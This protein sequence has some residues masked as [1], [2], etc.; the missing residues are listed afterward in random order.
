MDST[1]S[2]RPHFRVWLE[3]E[4]YDLVLWVTNLTNEDAVEQLSTGSS[5]NF[6]SLSFRTSAINREQRRFGITARYRF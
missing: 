4:N 1:N 2:D 5:Q 6:N 3:R